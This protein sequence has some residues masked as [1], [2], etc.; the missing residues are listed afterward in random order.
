[1]N[2]STPAVDNNSAPPHPSV[3]RSKPEKL[4]EALNNYWSNVLHLLSLYHDE[5]SLTGGCMVSCSQP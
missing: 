2:L 3:S 1:M 4:L 5:V